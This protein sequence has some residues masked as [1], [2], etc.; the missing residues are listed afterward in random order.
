MIDVHMFDRFTSLGAASLNL[1]F[2]AKSKRHKQ[3]IW[4]VSASDFFFLLVVYFI[5]L[6][7]FL[8]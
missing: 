1:S 5:F 6:S 4:Y 7:L 3:N 2:G 8:N